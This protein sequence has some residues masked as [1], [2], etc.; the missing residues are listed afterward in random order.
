MNNLKNVMSG[1]MKDKLWS[2]MLKFRKGSNEGASDKVSIP[3][4]IQI[5][6]IVIQN[7]KL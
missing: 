7:V 5:N 6:N 4:F 3:I 1:Q 2:T